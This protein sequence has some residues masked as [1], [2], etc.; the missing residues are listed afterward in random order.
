MQR[1][2]VVFFLSEMFVYANMNSI[3]MC[4]INVQMCSRFVHLF[5]LYIRASERISIFCVIYI[6]LSVK[7]KPTALLSELCATRL[8]HVT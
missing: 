2:W 6:A 5:L 7:K 3:R 1:T 4:S 8:K